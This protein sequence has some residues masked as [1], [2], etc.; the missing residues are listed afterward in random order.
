MLFVWCNDYGNLQHKS[1]LPTF[2]SFNISVSKLETGHWND[3]G[4]HLDRRVEI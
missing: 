2:H 4:H 1:K 3:P